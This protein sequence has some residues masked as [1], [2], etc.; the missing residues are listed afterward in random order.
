MRQRRI[1]QL[2]ELVRKTLVFGCQGLYDPIEP[3]L[4]SQDSLNEPFKCFAHGIHIRLTAIAFNLNS[5]VEDFGIA[6]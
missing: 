3:A 5:A 6:A 4:V 2:L 1:A